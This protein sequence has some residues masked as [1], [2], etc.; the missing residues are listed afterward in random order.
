MKKELLK[1][2]I[3]VV[4]HALFRE[5]NKNLTEALISDILGEKVKVITSDRDR[6]LNIKDP[7]QKFGIMDLRTELEG[8]VKCNIELQVDE[9]N[10][11]TERFL[12]YWADA[13]SRQ[14]E[15]GTDYVVLHKTISIIILDH[16][17]K[18]LK[19]MEEL[20]TKW[21]IRDEKTGERLLTKHLEIIIIEIPKA[22]R[23]YKKNN[24]NKIGQWMMFF[25]NPNDEEVSYIVENNEEIRKAN[26]ELDKMSDDETLRRIAELK[27]KGRRDYNARMS[28]IENKGME[29]GLQKGMEQGMKQGMKQGITIG[30]REKS[31][32]FAEKLIKKGLDINFIE[33]TTGLDKE[34][35]E[36]LIK[37][38]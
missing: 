36:K 3:D 27:E 23:I 7:D 14:L 28:F 19:D 30:K 33:E 22:R 17:L 24:K 31:I 11:E 12:Y 6:H 29:R 37:N 35:I 15:K 26:E 2:K 21:Q 5:E 18:E 9:M 32:E 13:Y 10:F 20:G 25:D 8:G 38:K 1:P 16:E 4:F 34:T